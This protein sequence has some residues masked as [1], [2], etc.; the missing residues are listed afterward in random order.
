MQPL[1]HFSNAI[2]LSCVLVP[3]VSGQLA[4]A[5]DCMRP[6][7]TRHAVHRVYERIPVPQRQ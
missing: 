5:D 6:R 3:M 7:R 1:R 4:A 2:L